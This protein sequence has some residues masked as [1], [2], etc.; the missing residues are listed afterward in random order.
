MRRGLVL[1]LIS[2]CLL[3]WFLRPS[4]PPQNFQKTKI[5]VKKLPAAS[6]SVTKSP[7]AKVSS[8][9][10][11]APLS[12]QDAESLGHECV[13][14]LIEKALPKL[15][16]FQEKIT[17]DPTAPVGLWLYDAEAP[18]RPAITPSASDFFLRGLAAANLLT[19]R[20]NKNPDLKL[21]LDLLL[22]AHEKDSKNAAAIVYAAYLQSQLG[23]EIEAQELLTQIQIEDMKFETY[24]IETIHQMYK[25]VKTT[26][27]ALLVLQLRDQLPVASPS[28]INP[29]LRA[30]HRQDIG[31]LM[32]Q[33]ELDP[34]SKY[35]SQTEGDI[36]FYASGYSH[37]RSLSSTEA[38]KYPHP[39]ILMEK[40]KDHIQ[41]ELVDIA[42][43]GR[44]CEAEK[45]QPYVDYFQ[46]VAQ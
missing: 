45:L 31:Y 24:Q 19:T 22:R 32:I 9:E 13:G 42:E 12:P 3:A 46:D 27:D 11:V 15:K 14:I 4:S 21:A 40:I 25:H 44:G 30:V 43:L 10:T 41:Y 28:E 6:D 33:N 18:I 38:E 8:S 26:E 7:A 16:D 34:Q 36:L 39:R 29:F 35:R 17:A 5:H 1:T 23:N 20:E 2:G 37:I